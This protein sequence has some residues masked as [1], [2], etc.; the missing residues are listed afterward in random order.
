MPAWPQL[1]LDWHQMWQIWYLL[2]WNFSLNFDW[3]S[4]LTTNFPNFPIFHIWNQTVGECDTSGPGF[5]WRYYN[6]LHMGGGV[7][8]KLGLDSAQIWQIWDFWRTDPKKTQSCHIWD[9]SDPF[10]ANPENSESVNVQVISGSCVPGAA[11]FIMW[12]L[13]SRRAGPHLHTTTPHRHLY[14]W[15]NWRKWRLTP[16]ECG[17]WGNQRNHEGKSVLKNQGQ[18]EDKRLR[19]TN[20]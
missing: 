11:C 3:K 17:E 5:V 19:W 2:N 6:K 8:T 12:D 16:G 4:Q 9:Q 15:R 14:C 18:C 10:G 1:G 7:G 13:S 20:K